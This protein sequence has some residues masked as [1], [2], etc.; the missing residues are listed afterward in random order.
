MLIDGLNEYEYTISNSSQSSISAY[1]FA[2]TIDKCANL[3]RANDEET[4]QVAEQLTFAK[5]NPPKVPF[6][7]VYELE[8]ARV[9]A[10]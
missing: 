7:S 4:A 5:L 3:Q 2:M 9:E 6:A 1:A 8:A 10:E